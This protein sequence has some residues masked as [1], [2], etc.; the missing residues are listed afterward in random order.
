M[1]FCDLSTKF[2]FVCGILK[3]MLI[4][5]RSFDEIAIFCYRLTTFCKL[6]TKFTFFPQSFD[7]RSVFFA[8]F[9]IKFGC[10]LRFFDE[11]GT[12]FF[13]IFWWKSQVFRHR[14]VNFT[15]FCDL[16]T[17]SNFFV[18]FWKNIHFLQS[19]DEITVFTIF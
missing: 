15:C 3:K 19:F 18:A 10:V 6:F 8:I 14:R 17:K 13:V 11:V 7:G 1:F 16:S 2:T 9:L 5:F 4:I 12:I